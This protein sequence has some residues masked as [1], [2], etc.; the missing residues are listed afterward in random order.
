M[1]GTKISLY[2]VKLVRDRVVTFPGAVFEDT[3]TAA[4]FFH[5][6]I[7]SADREHIAVLFLDEHGVPRGASIVGIGTVASVKVHAREIFKAAI[8]ASADSI[9]IAHNHVGAPFP[10]PEDLRATRSLVLA[11]KQ[12]GIR[13]RDHL[14]VAPS[15]AFVSM[16]GLGMLEED[17]KTG[18][19]SIN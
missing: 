12:L 16:H 7:G 8:L 5:R 2:K 19:N 17:E 13:I 4:A 15:G 3:R 11:S 18:S 6:L 10:S 9:I 1:K 14:I